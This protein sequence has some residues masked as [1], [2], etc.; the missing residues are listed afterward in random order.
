M[1]A[2]TRLATPPPRPLIVF[3]G[4]CRFCRIW[5]ARLRQ[6][7]DEAADYV[8][9]QDTSLAERFPEISGQQFETAVHLLMPDGSVFNG[10]EA[11]FRAMALNPKEQWF[12]DWYL[13]SKTFA[14]ASES[15]YAFIARHRTTFSLLTRIGWGTHTERPTYAITRAVFVR[16]LGMIY[17]IAFVSLWVQIQG[18]VGSNGILPAQQ[19]METVSQQAASAHLHASRFHAFPTLCWLSA[20]DRALQW[21]C[22]A[23]TVLSLLVIFGIAPAPALFLLWVVYLSLCTVCREF[24]S[25][26]WDILLLE[27]GFLAVFFAPLQLLPRRANPEPSRAILW[28]VRWLLFRLMFES[29]CVKLLSGDPAWR[30][31]TALSFH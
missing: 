14:S 19:T 10:A 18:L 28:L 21:Q 31:L 30:N 16:G 13:Y 29:G 11:M 15:I 6:I 5:I 20:S 4:D 22:G 17:L 8:Q 23:G 25:F 2:A 24:L 26:Q 27:T 3:D 7:T 1:K 9:Y 12:L